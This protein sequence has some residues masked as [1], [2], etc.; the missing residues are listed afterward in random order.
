MINAG[1]S[2]LNED[3]ACCEVV[4]LRKRPADPSSPSYTPTRRRSSLPSTD[5][6]ESIDSTVSQ[7]SLQFLSVASVHVSDQKLHSLNYFFN[8]HSLGLHDKSH[9][10]V[11]RI[12]SVKPVSGLCTS[13]LHPFSQAEQQYLMYLHYCKGQFMVGVGVDVNKTQSNR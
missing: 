1:K 3:Q 8:L 6:P 11:M 12:S 7:E 13:I 4:E 5:I 10:I 9:E 2:S